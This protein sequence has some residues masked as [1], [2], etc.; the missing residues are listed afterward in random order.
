MRRFSAFSYPYFSEWELTQSEAKGL[1]QFNLYLFLEF[2]FV[3]LGFHISIIPQ[4]ITIKI[5]KR[6]NLIII[7]YLS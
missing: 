1:I 4:N 2:L 6:G 7:V 5:L 3:K